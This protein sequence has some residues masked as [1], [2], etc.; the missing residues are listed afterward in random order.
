[1]TT[2]ATWRITPSDALWPQSLDALGA[3]AP[4][5][6]FIQGIN[7]ERLACLNGLVVITGSRAATSYGESVATRI[8]EDLTRDHGK[9]VVTG[10][11][12]GIE[13][14]ALRGV[15]STGGAPIVVLASGLNKLYPAGNTHLLSGV[16]NRGLLVSEFLDE[17]ATRQRFVRRAVVLAALAGTTVVVEASSPRSGALWVAHQAQTLGRRLGAVPGPITSGQSAGPHRLIA[18]GTAHL[19]TDARDI[20]ALTNRVDR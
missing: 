6:L 17:A 5:R 18:E 8:A 19:I 1:M 15:L 2:P 10:G 12:Y 20:A 7:P 9:T 4:T 11:S 13:T 16:P 3:D 14:A